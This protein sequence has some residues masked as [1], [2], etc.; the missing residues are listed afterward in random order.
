[1]RRLIAA[2][3]TMFVL[4]LTL[5]ISHVH[6]IRATEQSHSHG[7]PD[8]QAIFRYDTY[9]RRTAVDPS[10][11]DARSGCDGRISSDGVGGGASRSM[12]TH[13][14]LPSSRRSGG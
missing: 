13:C 4:A 9:W 1:M 5:A 14:H 6:P 11:A 3:S 10:P 12:W 7:Q 8:G 2:A